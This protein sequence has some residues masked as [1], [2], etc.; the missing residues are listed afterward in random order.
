MKVPME[1]GS[2]Q[3]HDL[4]TDAAKELGIDLHRFETDQYT[5]HATELIRW[6]RKTNLTSI[7]DPFE[8]AIKHFI[9][10]LA[11]HSFITEGSSVLDIG[12]GGGFPGIPLKIVFPSNSVLLVDASR[13]RVSF[14]K[15]VIRT[16][17]LSRIDAVH[18]RAEALKKEGRVPEGGFDVVV[19][20]ALT[21]FDRF[22]KLALPVVAEKGKIIALKGSDAEKEIEAF[23]KL[24]DKPEDAEIFTDKVFTLEVKKIFL[25]FIGD[26]RNIVVM[27]FGK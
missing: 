3:W 24:L 5:T 25:P 19:C 20:R 13:K 15:H 17:K 9:D 12:T 22:V 26:E 2:D 16:L 14:L 21:A 18:M 10:S 6:N 23:Q 7:T 27:D 1:I 4:L 11:S 8:I